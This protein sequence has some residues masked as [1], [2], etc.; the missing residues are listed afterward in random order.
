L[1]L[2]DWN[3]RFCRVLAKTSASG[4]DGKSNADT[5]WWTLKIG[6]L[7]LLVM[8]DDD[9]AVVWLLDSEGRTDGPAW[10]GKMAEETALEAAT[11]IG[12]LLAETPDDITFQAY[13]PIGTDPAKET[14]L[15]DAWA[16]VLVR[17]GRI[18]TDSLIDGRPDEALKEIEEYIDQ[19][20][21]TDATGTLAECSGPFKVAAAQLLR[22]E[23]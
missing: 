1:Q 20:A 17:I 10:S 18:R 6:P 7:G 21:R 4:I 2:K 13:A 12:R 22:G 23:P 8:D 19:R 5:G 11:A 16:D 15:N 14:V 9:E 3:D